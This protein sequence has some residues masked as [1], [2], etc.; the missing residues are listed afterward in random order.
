MNDRKSILVIAGMALLTACSLFSM[1][2]HQKNTPA[3]SQI[4]DGTAPLPPIPKGTGN[5][6]VV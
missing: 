3:P 4:A 2:Q 6:Y 1:N 5:L